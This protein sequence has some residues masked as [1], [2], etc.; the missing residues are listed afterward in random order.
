ME[1]TKKKRGHQKG[2]AMEGK[3]GLGVKTKVVRVPE[4]I[5]N[6]IAEIL[7]SFGDI[8]KLCDDWDEKAESSSPRYDHARKLLM[9][10]REHL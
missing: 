6:N 3:Y 9:E 8:K 4:N 7:E 5:A 1:S 2:V 10:L